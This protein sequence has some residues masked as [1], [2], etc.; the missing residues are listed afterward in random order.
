MSRTLRSLSHVLKAVTT[1]KTLDPL[2][3]FCVTMRD[4]FQSVVDAEKKT[5]FYSN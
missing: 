4:G 2:T 3:I 5:G 1:G